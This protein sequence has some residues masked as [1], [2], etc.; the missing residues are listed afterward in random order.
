MKKLIALAIVV[1]SCCEIL[2]AEPAAPAESAV[3]NVTVAEAEAL[4]KERKDVVVLD[5]RTDVEFQAGH[6]AG[7]KNIDFLGSDFAEK[8]AALDKAKTYLIHCGSGR[9]S[10][11][12][13]DVFK[14]QKFTSI[15]HLNEGFTAWQ[16]AG[17]P[18]EK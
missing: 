9:R 3:K 12:S 7:A 11:K 17:K 1:A 8:I 5:I 4:L 18:V 15:F 2:L 13:L 14:Q 6:I 16:S 10:T